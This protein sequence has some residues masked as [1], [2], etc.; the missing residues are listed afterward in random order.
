MPISD[1][2]V[3]NDKL[4]YILFIFQ[5]LV[6]LLF[7]W[8]LGD[9]NT[10]SKGFGILGVILICLY[11]VCFSLSWGPL[12][13]IVPSEIFP[14][15][16]RPLGQSINIGVLML[17]VFA[18]AQTFLA[19]L[20]HLKASIFFFFAGWVF[21]MTIFTYFLFP[22]TKLVPLEDITDLWKQHP[23]WKKYY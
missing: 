22:E 7:Q 9:H 8:K 17:F 19:M 16:I 6:G 18:T 21:V 3:I 14:L 10:I 15:E 5:V 2:P 11:I 12:A 23:I 4:V 20:C 1:S 13:W